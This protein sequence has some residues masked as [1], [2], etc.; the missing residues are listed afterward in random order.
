MAEIKFLNQ[1]LVSHYTLVQESLRSKCVKGET[2]LSVYLCV[3]VI[4]DG[5]IPTTQCYQGPASQVY[6]NRHH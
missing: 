4:Q 1:M 5:G 6:S 3:M 2:M